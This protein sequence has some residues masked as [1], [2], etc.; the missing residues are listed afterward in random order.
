MIFGG[1]TFQNV[2]EIRNIIAIGLD[3]GK[4]LLGID[5]SEITWLIASYIFK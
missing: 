3:E 5:K 1:N 2:L 4:Y